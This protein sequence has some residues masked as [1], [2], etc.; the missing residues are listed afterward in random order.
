[1]KGATGSSKRA[2]IT[3]LRNNAKN[4]QCFT[5]VTRLRNSAPNG[6][7]IA[8]YFHKC[9]VTK[10]TY[11]PNVAVVVTDGQGRVLLCERQLRDGRLIIQTVQ[12]GID[13][14]ETP[15]QAAY[16]ELEEEIGVEQKDV[17]ALRPSTT[18]W[19]YDFLPEDLKLF[20]NSTHIGQEQQFFLATIAPTSA[21]SL[22]HHHRE[23]TRVF[24]GTPQELKEKTWERKREGLALAMEEWGMLPSSSF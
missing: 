4:F 11:R 12:G 3:S 20:A 7:F 15:E 2:V 9:M 18:V 10:S 5:T 13:D 21:F 14:G 19:R 17:Q 1:M 6:M 23:F 8:K 22:D 16:R 24:W